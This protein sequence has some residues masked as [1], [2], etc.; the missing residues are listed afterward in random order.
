MNTIRYLIIV[1]LTILQ[2]YAEENNTPTCSQN[3]DTCLHKCEITQESSD[4]C[5]NICDDLYDVCME[6]LE[7]EPSNSK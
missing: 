4:N 1:S 3:Y 6:I 2:L 5:I 7:E